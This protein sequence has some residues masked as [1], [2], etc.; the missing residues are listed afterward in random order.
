MDSCAQRPAIAAKATA[1]KYYEILRHRSLP[2][3]L[4]HKPPTDAAAQT[5]TKTKT[6]E[7]HSGLPL[8]APSGAKTDQ[9]PSAATR[10]VNQD[11]T[12]LWA[13]LGST[14]AH[15]SRRLQHSIACISGS[16][17]HHIRQHG[18]TSDPL[19][20]RETKV[21]ARGRLLCV[22]MVKSWTNG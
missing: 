8:P 6:I 14:A 22:P 20:G 9:P 7:R 13:P 1:T 17:R 11:S 10:D 3:S 21:F 12:I 16:R 2:K 18:N 19:Q 15:F 4:R 5:S